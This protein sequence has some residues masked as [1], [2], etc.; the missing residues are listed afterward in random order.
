[1]DVSNFIH[2][3]DIQ[4]LAIE[5]FRDSRNQSPPIM[6]DI[7]HKRTIVGSKFLKPLV[8]S[9]HYGSE[10]VSFLGPKI[11]DMLAR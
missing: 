7:L 4:S 3:K 8:K 2:M 6:N 9:V 10:S 11:W 1:M 5:M